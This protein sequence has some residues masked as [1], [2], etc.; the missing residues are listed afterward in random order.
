MCGFTIDL[1]ETIQHHIDAVVAIEPLIPDIIQLAEKITACL[2][3][4][5]KVCWF[6]N[7]GSAADSQHF[8]AELVGR[9]S[10]ERPGLASIAL[11]TNNSILTAIANDYGIDAIFARQIEALCVS[12]DIVIGIS[13]SG[14]SRNILL[15][16]QAAKKLN[17]YTVGM[18]GGNGG[19]MQS[20]VDYC[21]IVPSTVTARI[22][23]V[24][25][26]I[27]HLL[28]DWIEAAFTKN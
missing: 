23:E 21:L 3:Q 24:H 25:L 8:A 9:F 12:K 26:L 2:L 27:G 1:A 15:G 18:T 6:G 14:N 28:C 13:T 5:G 10:R 19:E 7:G 16:L 22:Q 4:G 11:T 20:I 17:I